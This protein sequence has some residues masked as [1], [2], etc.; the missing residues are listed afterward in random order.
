MCKDEEFRSLSFYTQV[1]G[2]DMESWLDNQVVPPGDRA[3]IIDRGPAA[4]P[5]TEVVSIDIVSVVSLTR[6]F[7]CIVFC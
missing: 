3:G 4:E 6:A 2:P 5:G 1:P 7:V